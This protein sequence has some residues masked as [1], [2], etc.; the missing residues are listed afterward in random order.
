MLKSAPKSFCCKNPGLSLL[1]TLMTFSSYLQPWGQ[2]GLALSAHRPE[3]LP[4][5][6]LKHTQKGRPPR[7][8]HDVVP[9]PCCSL[10]LQLSSVLTL[11]SAAMLVW[12][13][14]G[15]FVLFLSNLPS[16]QPVTIS[17]CSTAQISKGSAGAVI[18]HSARLTCPVLW[19]C[20][21]TEVPKN[22]FTMVGDYYPQSVLPTD[23]WI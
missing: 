2:S 21:L 13:A 1:S 7:L 19:A 9:S 4:E 22:Y 11:L 18:L 14:L 23:S 20:G 3:N 16:S 5:N 12:S 15:V 8:A 10:L 6:K 17:S